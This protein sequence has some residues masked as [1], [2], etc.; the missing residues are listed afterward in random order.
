MASILAVIV[1]TLTIIGVVNGGVDE[2][3]DNKIN[4][5]EKE[6]EM[7]QQETVGEIKTD[8]A[9]LKEQGKAHQ[10][11]LDAIEDQGKHTQQLVE[12]LIRER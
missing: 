3:I 6:F 2:R 8:I 7:K 5:H 11:Q 10:R 9:T 1:A 12:Q 4:V